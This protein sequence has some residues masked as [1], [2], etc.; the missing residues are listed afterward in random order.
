[1]RLKSRYPERLEY[2]AS[3]KWDDMTGGL[4]ATSEDHSIKYDT[5][6]SFGGNG[7]G[8]CPDEMFVAAVLGCLN[9]TFLDFQRRF[10][11]V[12]KSFELE[13]TATAVFDGTGYSVTGLKITG[14]VVVGEDELEV[15]ERCVELMKEYCHITRTIRDCL[16]TEY[17]VHVSEE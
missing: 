4:A 3:S 2:R 10:E 7:N 17:D 15:G 5:P 11:M 16:P 12:L 8:V 14:S 13:G 6:K 1:M 9:N